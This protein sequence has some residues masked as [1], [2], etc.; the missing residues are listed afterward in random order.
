MPKDPMKTYASDYGKADLLDSSSWPSASEFG[1]DDSQYNA[2][3]A[4][5][6]TELSI[7]QG[8]PGKNI[9]N[10]LKVLKCKE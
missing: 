9:T 10:D 3:H 4:A 6:T 2:F 8:P 1:M 7:I 5:L